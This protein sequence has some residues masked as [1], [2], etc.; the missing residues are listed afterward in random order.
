MEEPTTISD[1]TTE[2]L[3]LYL[4]NTNY[5][6]A[7]EK[8]HIDVYLGGAKVTAEALLQ[9]DGA[10]W[11]EEIILFHFTENTKDD[12]T[13]QVRIDFDEMLSMATNTAV[14]YAFSDGTVSSWDHRADGLTFEEALTK[15][16]E[17][18]V[19]VNTKKRKLE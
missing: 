17:D 14:L 1:V 4:N 11:E 12:D 6:R 9:G 2:W 13:E 7:C 5:V 15:S 3:N 18:Y 10:N 8:F 16:Y 19:C